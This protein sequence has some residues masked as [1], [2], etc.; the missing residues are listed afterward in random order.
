MEKKRNLLVMDD[1][2][3][4]FV[5]KTYLHSGFLLMHSGVSNSPPA[6]NGVNTNGDLRCSQVELRC[7]HV[8]QFVCLTFTS[9]IFI[10]DVQNLAGSERFTTRDPPGNAH[11]V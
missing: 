10:N 2:L 1:M 6:R 11:P 8:D 7:Y 5:N 4:L 3:Y 9:L